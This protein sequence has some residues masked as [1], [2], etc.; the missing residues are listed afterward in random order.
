M[1][2]FLTCRAAETTV[3]DRRVVLGDTYPVCRLDGLD[4]DEVGFFIPGEQYRVSFERLPSEPG[5][6]TSSSDYDT[7]DDNSTDDADDAGD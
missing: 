2:I 4:E 7:D 1:Q 6:R 3:D 5:S